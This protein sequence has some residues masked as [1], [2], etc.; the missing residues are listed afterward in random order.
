M[1]QPN[2]S[3]QE[4][5]HSHE[6]TEKMKEFESRAKATVGSK[7]KHL[8]EP[9]PKKS[10]TETMRIQLEKEKMEEQ[11]SDDEW[12][13]FKCSKIIN[14][15]INSLLKAFKQKHRLKTFLFGKCKPLMPGGKAS[16]HRPSLE[17]RV[18]MHLILRLTEK[19]IIP[20]LSTLFLA[21]NLST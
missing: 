10:I 15:I 12:A 13:P 17:F 16:K 3:I 14:S 1:G 19:K 20:K 11:G 8:R 18:L 7:R 5:Q 9:S 21:L 4:H 6:S 2:S